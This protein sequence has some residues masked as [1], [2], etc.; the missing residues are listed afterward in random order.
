V[1]LKEKLDAGK[2]FEAQRIEQRI[3]KLRGIVARILLGA[4]TEVEMEDKKLR[5]EDAINALKGAIAEGMV[6]GGGSAYAY[7]MRYAEE[8]KA[9]LPEEEEKLG[10]DIIMHAIGAPC[11]QIADNAGVLGAMVLE[12]T[13]ELEWGHGFNAATLKYENLLEAGVCDPASVTTWALDNAASISASLLN[14]EAIVSEQTVFDATDLMQEQ[15]VGVG[16]G[17][18][19][20]D[21]AW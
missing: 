6:P 4:A 11:T 9:E 19:A 18:K 13:K 12:K 20:A 14:T 5:Y 17:S 2:E 15:D 8:F 10:V 16:I 21:Y 3:N 1:Q 7:I